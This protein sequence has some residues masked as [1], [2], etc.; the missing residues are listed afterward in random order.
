MTACTDRRL[1]KAALCVSGVTSVLLFTTPLALPALADDGSGVVATPTVDPTDGSWVS[2]YVPPAAAKPT[3]T[4]APAPGS[5]RTANAPVA[6][7]AAAKGAPCPPPPPQH[8]DGKDHGFFTVGMKKGPGAHQFSLRL[9]FR[10]Y[11]KDEVQNAVVSFTG[12]APTGAGTAAKVLSGDTK[13]AFMGHQS[14][15]V[16]DHEDTFVLDPSVL[17]TPAADGWHVKIDVPI[18]PDESASRSALVVLPTS[19]APH[20]KPTVSGIKVKFPPA[21]QPSLPVTGSDNPIKF[22]SMAF[23][24][25]S[26]GLLLWYVGMVPARRRYQRRH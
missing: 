4:K 3:P 6:A 2:I 12:V 15:D 14:T 26:T 25:F 10:C 11:D 19:N 23:W 13:F 20:P 9:I 24:A 5:A 22:V 18:V 8:H 7:S 17:G 16:I 21:V 1:L